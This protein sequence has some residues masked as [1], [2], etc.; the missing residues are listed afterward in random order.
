MID[1][2]PVEHLDA[3]VFAP[4]WASTGSTTAPGRRRP[5]CGPPHRWLRSL[6]QPPTD[7]FGALLPRG[8][9]ALTGDT[10]AATRCSIPPTARVPE[11]E[12]D[13]PP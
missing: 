2:V 7:P 9:A 10:V 1:G 4:D 3:R 5:S 8:I 11:W 13:H 6:S 12:H